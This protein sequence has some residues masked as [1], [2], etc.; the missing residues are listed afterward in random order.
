MD[1]PSSPI[2]PELKKV[3]KTATNGSGAA[4]DV[5]RSART[6]K[7]PGQKEVHV[8]VSSSLTLRELKQMQLQCDEVY[9]C[10]IIGPSVEPWNTLVTEPSHLQTLF[11]TFPKPQVTAAQGKRRESG[12]GT[13]VIVLNETRSSSG[14]TLTANYARSIVNRERATLAGTVSAAGYKLPGLGVRVG[15]SCL[16]CLLLDCQRY[17]SAAGYKLPGLGTVNVTL[18]PRVTNCL[19]GLVV[20]VGQSCLH[21]LLLDCQRY[22][23]AAGYK[24]PGLGLR[25][26]Q[27]CQHCLLLD[28]Q[29]YFSAAGYKLPGLGVRVGQSCLHCL[30]LECQ[31]Y[32]STKGYKLPGLGVRVGQSCLHCLLLD[33]QRHFSAAGYKL[34]AWTCAP[35]V[36][37]CLP[38]LV[39]RVGQSCQHCLLLDCQQYCSTK[40]YKLPGLGVRVG[41]SCLH[42]LLLDCQR[43]FSA[44]GY[45]LPAWTCGESRT[46]LPALSPARLSTVL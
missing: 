33:C 34:P 21:C 10:N 7:V 4:Q 24:L 13:P 37:N 20:R 39:V 44:A 27:S 15:Q 32:C 8:T 9:K 23:S 12:H 11:V 40:G 22:F 30:L 35:R 2:P 46:V 38:G 31:Q 19:P 42:C 3:M 6:R 36:T 18:A 45:K 16:H 14:H 43:H 25:V 41:Q 26:G 28:C 17:F 1:G 5:R 29:R